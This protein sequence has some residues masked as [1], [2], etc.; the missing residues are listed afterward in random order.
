MNISKWAL[1]TLAIAIT[2]YGAEIQAQEQKCEQEAQEWQAEFMYPDWRQT[3]K[4]EEIL[5]EE[6]T[7]E[8]ELV[9]F[10]NATFGKVLVLDGVIQTT[11]NDEFIYHEMI[12]HV[13][14]LS[15]GNAK[16]VLIIGGG[17]GGTLREVLRHKT[18]ERVVIVEID[19]A[20]ITFCKE[21]FPKHSNGGFE[22]PRTEIVI[23]DGSQFVKET[24]E[25]FDVIICD[26]CDPIGPAAVLFTE[27]FFGDCQ[28]LL[29]DSGI[30]VNQN[31]V[32]FMQKEQLVNTNVNLR[33]HF[34]ETGFYLAAVP[35]Y[36]GGFMAFAFATN[37]PEYRDIAKKELRKRLGNIEGGLRYYSPE[38]HEAAFALP[39][40]IKSML[41]T[42]KRL[43]P[44]YKKGPCCKG[45]TIGK[46]AT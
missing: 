38:I 32:P 7:G 27:E 39:G 2:C 10:K 33:M 21:H 9:I 3:F 36:M 11:E 14:L 34:R 23:Q 35:T 5:Y 40:F 26:S 30:F 12:A 20:V 17:D 37:N 19:P 22:D 1:T 4:V 42:P 24:K 45:S 13:P 43:P 31:G 15:H 6:K 18:V 25:S 46:E 44:E 16:K 41:R 28:K 29:G 8:Q